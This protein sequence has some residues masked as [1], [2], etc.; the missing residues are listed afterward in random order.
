MMPT[1]ASS[2]AGSITVEIHT[3]TLDRNVNGFQPISKTLRIDCAAKFGVAA[4][5]RTSAPDALSLTISE[6]MV[7][8]V[9]S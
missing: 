6:S 2:P 9:I 1:P 8:W 5:I 4:M 7:G 3:P